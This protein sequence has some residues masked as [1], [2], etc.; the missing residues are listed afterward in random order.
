MTSLQKKK[1]TDA[2]FSA[3]RK[4][5]LLEPYKLA[6][7][8]SGNILSRHLFVFVNAVIFSVVA[9]LFVFGDTKS[10]VFLGIIVFFNV[11]V[12]IA[13][14]FNARV[15]LEKLQLLTAVRFVRVNEDDS[16]ET[17]FPDEIKVGDRILL[18]SGDQIPCDSVIIES[19]SLEI[20]EAL[21]TGESDSLAKKVGEG[22]PAGGII[23]AG[24]GSIR[25]KTLY[26]ESRIAKMTA[27]SRRYTTNPSPIQRSV[28]K[29]IKYSSYALAAI[30]VFVAYRGYVTGEPIEAIVKNAGA[31]A[32]IIVP[33]GLIVTATLFFA[34]GAASYSRRHV[35]FQDI[36]ATEKLGR[37]KN[38]CMDKT[39]TLTENSLVVEEM[40]IPVGM[41]KEVAG[42]LTLLYIKVSGESSQTI[43]AVKKYLSEW[44]EDKDET[45]PEILDVLPFSSWRQYGAITVKGRAGPEMIITGAPD[46]LLPYLAKDKEKNDLLEFIER[47]AR[48]GKRLL[49][50]FRSPGTDIQ[51]AFSEKT[52]FLVSTFVFRTGF[53]EGVRDAIK[54]FQD[55]GVRIRIISGDNLETTRAVA[56]LAGV[57]RSDLTIT[58]SEMKEW[59]ETDFAEKTKNYSIFARVLPEQKVKLIE[60]L[61]HDGFTAMVGDGANDA[62]AVK[63]SNLGV[64]MFDG[65]KATRQLAAVVLMNNSFSALPGAVKLADNFIGNIEVFAMTFLSQSFLGFF[66][67]TIVSSFGY[68][69]PLTPLNVT[70]I[71]YF[72]VGLPGILVVYWA[73]RPKGDIPPASKQGFLKRVVPIA[74]WLGAIEAIGVASVFVFSPDYLKTSETNTLVVLAFMIFGLIFFIFASSI[75]HKITLGIQKLQVLGLCV[76]ELML[77]VFISSVPFLTDFFNVDYQYPSPGDMG[78]F[79]IIIAVSSLALYV[80]VKLFFKKELTSNR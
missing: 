15:S 46:L 48:E 9:L 40:N 11:F 67:F 35:L 44:D 42:S 1:N 55:R 18:K 78:K 51:K 76:A 37:I 22:V 53:R 29:I 12:G 4:G 61:K 33:Q 41:A 26:A 57:A 64:A 52:F 14:D 5:G 27:S 38:L 73:V 68:M 69:F 66:F 58:G 10:A 63:I 54:F 30:L 70:L 21:L 7:L 47:N 36:N 50:V 3:G 60:A 75:R 23:T 71:N 34:F 80:F 28:A 43:N 45:G 16:E 49:T 8:E 13:Q 39:G 25:I 31:L 24:T 74:A 32:S 59:S 2:G 6:F 62:L 77:G 65:A 56:S 72:A 17:V 79:S 19:N 20:S